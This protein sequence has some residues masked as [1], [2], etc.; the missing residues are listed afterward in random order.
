MMTQ[1][2]DNQSSRRRSR[3]TLLMALVGICFGVAIF[4]VVLPRAIDVGEVRDALLNLSWLGVA[5][6][7]VA[8]IL[9]V[10]TYGPT[11]MAAMPGLRYWPAQLVTLT[12]TAS[13]YLAPGGGAVGTAVSFGILRAWGFPRRRVTI[14]LGLYTLWGQGATFGLPAAALLTLTLTGGRDPVLQ[15]IA[16]IGF[17]IFLAVLAVLVISLW[18]ART[19]RWAGNSAAVVV[20]GLLTRIRRRPVGWSGAHVAQIRAEILDLGRARWHWLTLATLTGL[21]TVY[22]VLLVAVR[23]VG[24][25]GSEVSV[26]ESFAAWTLAR[27]LGAIPIAPGGFGVVDVGLTAALIGFGG[28]GGAVVTA[29]LLYRLLTVAPP[30]ACGALAG[31]LWQ[32]A[33]PGMLDIEDADPPT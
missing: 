32:R 29:V 5:A 11:L 1:A 20:S 2:A 12:A 8:A 6:L 21:L 13:G 3:R 22:L 26:V 31:S 33:H 19:A 15:R 4:V 23:A 10:A 14:A 9:N 25:E 27:L 28:N 16:L 7:V 17:I 18:S 30:L 24:I